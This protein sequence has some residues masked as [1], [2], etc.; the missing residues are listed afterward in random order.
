[1]NSQFSTRTFEPVGKALSFFFCF[2]V[3]DERLL[4]SLILLGSFVCR[5]AAFSGAF[6]RP[7]AGSDARVKVE[8]LGT[9]L[10]RADTVEARVESVALAFIGTRVDTVLSRTISVTGFRRL[11]FGPRL[12]PVLDVVDVIAGVLFRVLVWVED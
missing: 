4:G 7:H 11:Q 12:A 10:A 6:S 3:W 8:T 1:M 5:E 2:S 9:L